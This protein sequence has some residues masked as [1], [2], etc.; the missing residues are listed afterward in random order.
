VL[1]LKG[2]QGSAAPGAIERTLLDHA[3]TS[4]VSAIAAFAIEQERAPIGI[5]D[6]PRG[7]VPSVRPPM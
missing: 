4:H 7:R 6:H 2:Q 3:W 1:V 5:R